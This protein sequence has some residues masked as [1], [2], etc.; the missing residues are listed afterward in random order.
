MPKVEIDE[1][2]WNKI[3]S[4][5]GVLKSIAANPK[6]AKLVEQAHKLVD[7]NAPTPKIEAEAPLQEA[8]ENVNKTIVELRKERE[9]EKLAAKTERDLTALKHRQDAGWE[10]LR[11]DRRFLPEGLKKIQEIM[12]AKGILDPE[13][14]AA[15]F[16]RDNPPPPPAMPGG[17]GPWNFMEAP[18]EQGGEDIKK[19]IDS[20]GENGLL[21]DK[22]TR[23]ALTEIRG[24]QPRR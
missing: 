3:Q 23:E 19:L 13:D 9:E 1:A 24:N 15:I 18:A 5:M 16:E 17:T 12:D 11:N 21:L 2:E 7:P 4:T 14:A 20:K 22:M 10:K 8:L 6:A